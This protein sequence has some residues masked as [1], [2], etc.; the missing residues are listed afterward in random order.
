[1]AFFPRRFVIVLL[2][3]IEIFIVFLFVKNKHILFLATLRAK[4]N[5]VNPYNPQV[6]LLKHY[7]TITN[8][9]THRVHRFDCYLL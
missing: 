6:S 1:M 3:R 8:E 5:N 4:T 7:P 9:I 2:S